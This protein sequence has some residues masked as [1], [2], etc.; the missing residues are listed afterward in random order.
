MLNIKENKQKIV[1]V[2]IKS[3]NCHAFYLGLIRGV[4]IRE[5]SQLIKEWLKINGIQ[6]INN[7][8]DA[9][10]LVMLESGQPLHIFDYD[11]LPE[12]KELV[13]RQAREGEVMVSLQNSSL[14]L[15]A[16][17]IVISAGEKIIDLAGIIG[18]R[19]TA[20]NSQ[21]RSIFV[22]CAAFCSKTIKATTNRLNFTTSAS[23]YFCR[24]NSTFASPEYILQRVISLIINSYRG[25]L[26]S[27]EF[28][29]YQ[30]AKKKELTTTTITQDFIEKKIGQK[31]PELIIENL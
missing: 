28:F 29:I 13:V 17:D 12:K 27:G 8:V 9:A 24:E 15:R 18:A 21:T 16:E 6:P 1:E 14:T 4:E 25:N 19:E 2:K 11:S 26:N 3:Q 20:V 30:A 31:I 5:S 23:R 22:E 7:V 10:N